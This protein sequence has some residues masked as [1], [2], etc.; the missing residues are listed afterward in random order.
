LLVATFWLP[1]ETGAAEVQKKPVM[2]E[3]TVPPTAEVF[4]D[5]AKT[6]KTGPKRS[7]ISPEVEINKKYYFTIKAVWKEDGKEVVREVKFYVTPGKVN[8]LDL[9]KEQKEEPK[10]AG[11]KL[12]VPALVTVDAGGKKAIPLKVTRENLKGAVKVAFSGLPPGVK[13]AAV[14]IP[15]DKS[16]GSAEVTAD[17][18]ATAGAVDVAVSAESGEVKTS[19]KLKLSVKAAPPLAKLTLEV[20]ATFEV[21]AGGKKPLTVKVK[22]ENAE[23]PVKVTFTGLPPGIMTPELTLAPDKSEGTVEIA[24]AKDTKGGTSTVTVA[25]AAGSTKAAPV[26]IKLTVKAA[27]APNPK[28]MFSVMK[29]AALDITPGAKKPLTVKIKRED[30]QG[31]VKV[32]F[33]KVPKGI[34][35]AALTIPADKSEGK[36]EVTVDKDANESSVNVTIQAT[37]GDI[38]AQTSA[39]LN[40]KAAKPKDQ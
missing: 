40:I 8:E 28:G 38:K 19:T 13:I 10:P 25:A 29:P 1:A 22:R 34:K 6:K 5:G 11:L 31:P 7:Y 32:T 30:V 36:A 16:D 23:G 26:E 17:K 12:D 39:K 2:V 18:D 14:T 35:I 3:V 27:P 24:P 21:D 33:S 15:A 4:I 20:P 9:T 37:S